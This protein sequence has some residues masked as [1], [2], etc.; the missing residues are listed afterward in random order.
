[1]TENGEFYALIPQDKK[2]EINNL[3]ME[4]DSY[5]EITVRNDEENRNLNAIMVGY[6]GQIKK[7]DAL[8]KKAI[9]PYYPQV[10]Y[11]NKFYNGV[12]ARVKSFVN[13]CDVALGKYER[14]QRIKRQAEQAKRD[15]AATEIRRKK[16]EA[17]RK[18]M[19]KAK[20][21]AARGRTKMSAEAE[22]RAEEKIEEAEQAVAPIVEETKLDST[23][24]VTKYVATVTDKAGAVEYCLS[25]PALEGCV[26][27]NLK[28]I[29]RQQNAAQGKW[30]IPG[31]NFEKQLKSR[32]R[33]Q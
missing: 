33:T 14:D 21:Y 4:L 17:A 15:A 20:R 8:R 29:E 27:L 22:A 11:F 5:K 13:N 1:M 24:F 16:E 26:D 32:S 18:E 28:A 9:E 25:I 19:E 12:I 6:K 10:T 31:I 23:S 7:I 3:L 2:D 30:E